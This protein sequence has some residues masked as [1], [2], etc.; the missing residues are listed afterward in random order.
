MKK[1]SK[2]FDT[3][4]IKFSVAPALFN[5]ELAKI[6]SITGRRFDPT[7]KQWTI[8]LTVPNIKLLK[9]FGYELD[10]VL[11]QMIGVEDKPLPYVS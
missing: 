11:A 6:K 8:P 1:A 3:I 7:S 10:A 4:N 9:S 2:L 5:T